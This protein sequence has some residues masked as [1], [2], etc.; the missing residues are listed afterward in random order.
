[1][2]IDPYTALNAMIRAEAVR[3]T[4][5]TRQAEPTAPKT[6]SAAVESESEPQQESAAADTAV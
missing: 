5:P 3:Y 2:P 6:P 4:P 1:M